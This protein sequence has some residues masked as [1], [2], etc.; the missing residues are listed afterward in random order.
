[1][2]KMMERDK[3]RTQEGLSPAPGFKKHRPSTAE[4]LVG[5]R[6]DGIQEVVALGTRL[7]TRPS[8]SPEN[9]RSSARPSPSPE[10]TG[11]IAS[12]SPSPESSKL[13]SQSDSSG[14]ED[15]QYE[16]PSTNG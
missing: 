1:M 11:S 3:A 14:S 2:N 7:N 8:P 4:E 10:C 9:T 16:P 12:P 6:G 13:C 5:K 15:L